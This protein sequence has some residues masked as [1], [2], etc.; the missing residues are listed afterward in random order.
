MIF[1]KKIEKYSLLPADHNYINYLFCKVR[2]VLK[3]EIMKN[4]DKQLNLLLFE[5]LDIDTFEVLTAVQSNIIPF[6]KNIID[7]YQIVDYGMNK[8]P[9]GIIITQFIKE[10][11]DFRIMKFKSKICLCFN[12]DAISNLYSLWKKIDKIYTIVEVFNA[13][14]QIDQNLLKK[15]I[16]K[17]LKSRNKLFQEIEMGLAYFL[18]HPGINNRKSIF[19]DYSYFT[20]SLTKYAKEKKYELIK[21]IPKYLFLGHYHLLIP[22]K[23]KETIIILSGHGTGYVDYPPYNLINAGIPAVFF[24]SIN[25]NIIKIEIRR[26]PIGFDKIKLH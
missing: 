23:F 8:V 7:K 10:K 2:C 5:L 16:L 3:V 17:K 1:F 21:P 11:V 15:L 9:A 26:L 4:I 18:N 25:N 12:F 22:F 20:H 24:D 6:N 14:R 13:N 19:T